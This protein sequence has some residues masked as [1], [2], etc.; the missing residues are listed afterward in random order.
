MFCPNCGSEINDQANFCPNCGA[1]KADIQTSQSLS[2]IVT[3]STSIQPNQPQ[4]VTKR[5]RN[6]T[7]ILFTLILA[8]AIVGVLLYINQKKQPEPLPPV[9]EHSAA[10]VYTPAPEVQY[11]EEITVEATVE[12]EPTPNITAP[13]DLA[14]LKPFYTDY[15]STKLTGVTLQDKLGNNYTNCIEYFGGADLYAGGNVTTFDKRD[16]Y[17]L[18]GKYT[19]FSATIFVPEARSSFWDREINDED[20]SRG[21]FTVRIFGDGRL[22]YQSPLMIST[23]YPVPVEVDI[24][25]VDQLSI[26]WAT[27]DDVSSEIGLADVYL[28]VD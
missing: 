19:T 27:F 5:P 1:R 28:H 10:P 20:K 2:P 14:S 12:P 11:K 4:P 16:T 13:V 3:P 7:P 24:S 17:V 22:L 23:Q 21:S 26:S 18:G 8:I 6:N 9:E 25:G 15:G